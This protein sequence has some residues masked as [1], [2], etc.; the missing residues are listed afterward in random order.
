M[1]VEWASGE[2]DSYSATWNGTAQEAG[3][4]LTL[5]IGSQYV[6]PGVTAPDELNE[7]YTLS[8]TGVSP[9]VKKS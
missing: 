9:A 7:A 5:A 2:V 4:T 8:Y 6:P 1:I 3:S